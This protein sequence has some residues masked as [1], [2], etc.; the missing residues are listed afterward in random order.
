L[1]PS[2]IIGHLLE[3]L[4]GNAPL[5]QVLNERIVKVVQVDQR[6]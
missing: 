2:E 1:N 4:L 3:R 5:S 6:G